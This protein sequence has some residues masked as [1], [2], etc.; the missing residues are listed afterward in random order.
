MD[1][2]VDASLVLSSTGTGADAVQ[3][4]ASVGGVKVKSGGVISIGE[5]AAT[6]INIGRD[7]VVTAIAGDLQADITI[8]S[9]LNI[10]DNIQ[11]LENYE[12]NFD[13]IRSVS[14]VYKDEYSSNS[15]KQVGF[16]AQE[17]EEIFPET[18]KT[19]E[20]TGLK[21]VNYNYF[22]GM[23]VKEVQEL[24]NRVAILENN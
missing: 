9:D 6:A 13:Q 11:D 5:T 1:G 4:T 22:I 3:L 20:T 10:K 7:G 16:I 12:D 8:P 18:V 23:L 21:T 2:A 24:R 19:N 17:L 14:F 15:N